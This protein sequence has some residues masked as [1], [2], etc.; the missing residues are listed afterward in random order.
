[1]WVVSQFETDFF[2]GRV[3]FGSTDSSRPMT[4]VDG[5]LDDFATPTGPSGDAV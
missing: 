4:F 2:V 3:D 1:M 5:F